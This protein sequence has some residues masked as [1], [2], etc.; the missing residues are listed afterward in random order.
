M[1]E[2]S[3]DWGLRANPGLGR[4]KWAVPGAGRWPLVCP[5]PFQL[6][7]SLTIS[8]TDPVMYTSFVHGFS[9][10]ELFIYGRSFM[11]TLLG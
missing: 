5:L 6:L 4:Q 1:F 3:S 11:V 8:N 9:I 2:V 7:A 10:L